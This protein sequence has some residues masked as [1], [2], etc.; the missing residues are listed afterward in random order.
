ME[1]EEE[2]TRLS[3]GTPSAGEQRS[4]HVRRGGT[5]MSERASALSDLV[6][7][8]RYVNLMINGFGT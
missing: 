6:C 5:C 8:M 1:E 3:V 4:G 7:G 2:E